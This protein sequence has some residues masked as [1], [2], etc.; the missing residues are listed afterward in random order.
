MEAETAR[1]YE[2]VRQRVGVAASPAEATAEFKGAIDALARQTGISILKMDHRKPVEMAAVE[3]FCVDIGNFEGDIKNAVRFLQET[4]QAPGLLRVV[5][6]SL[7]PGGSKDMVK[8]ALSV[9]KLML[10]DPAA[11]AEAEAPPA[12]S[13]PK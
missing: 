1:E 2:Q 13:A 10:K 12:S 11:A 8:G 6:L 3:E 5:K 9:T 4:R 7:V